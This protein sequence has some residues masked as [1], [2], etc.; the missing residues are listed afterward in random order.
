M[1]SFS[2]KRTLLDSLSTFETQLNRALEQNALLENELDEKQQVSDVVLETRSLSLFP[3][4]LISW[5]K[6]YNDCVTK[7]ETC[8]KNSMY[9]TRPTLRKPSIQ[10]THLAK[11]RPLWIVIEWKVFYPKRQLPEQYQHM[12]LPIDQVKFK[13]L[14]FQ[15]RPWWTFLWVL[16]WT[17][18]N[19]LDMSVRWWHWL[20]CKVSRF[21]SWFELIDRE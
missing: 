8:E 20:K 13:R 15:T 17:S 14:I 7:R 6:R 21:V 19:C 12:I 18:N 5:L 1:R 4:L 10:R 2:G 9:C 11:E 3:S 16:Q